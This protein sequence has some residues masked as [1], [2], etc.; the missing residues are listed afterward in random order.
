[1]RMNK[2]SIPIFVGLLVV[3]AGA[4]T[5]GPAEKTLGV[6]V[7]LVYLHGAWVWTALLTF[8]LSAFS[9]TIGFL[10]RKALLHSWSIAL[11]RVGLV[12]WLSYLPLSL[13][14]MQANWNGLYLSEPRWKL[15]I[16]F[17]LAGIMLQAAII[18][19][20]RRSWG[21]IIN[22]GFMS[23]LIFNLMRTEQVMHPS[24]P[25]FS[26]NSAAIE[27]FF[28]GLTFLCLLSAIQL[29]RIFYQRTLPQSR[30]AEES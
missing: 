1:M 30:A 14:T 2:S 3:I 6:N 11:G 27:Y 23:L 19:L 29:A 26:S 21:S 17:A 9:G 28:L 8:A 25:V 18:I 10:S 22:M 24:S 4:T 5:L 7:R 12:Y 15:A 20:K 16:D 13:W